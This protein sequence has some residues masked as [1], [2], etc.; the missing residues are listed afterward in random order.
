MA[1]SDRPDGLSVVVI[2]A[3]IVG[4][5][6]A[7]WLARDG[8]RVT[9][10]DRA[11]YGEVASFGNGGVLAA[12]SIVPVTTPSLL[13]K[14]PLMML[15]PG[16][17]VFLRWK[18]VPRLTPWLVRYLSHCRASE[19]RRIAAAL[20]PIIGDSLAQHQALTRGTP[21]ARWVVP[22][23]YVYVY[24]DHAAFAADSL[25]WDVR[26]AAGVAWQVLDGEALRAFDPLI[27][28]D[29]RVAVRMPEH[30]H[31][32][33]PGRYLR[34]LG[35]HLES[36]GGSVRTAEARDFRIEGDRLT[37]VETDQ[38]PLPCDRAVLAGGV[39]SK[40]LAARLGLRVPL[41]T[42]RGYHLELLDPSHMPAHPCM[43]AA[44]KFVVTPMEGRL[45]LAGI[46][47]LGGLDDPPGEAPFRLLERRLREAMPDLRWRET[48]RWMG[49]RPA[50]SDS[51]PA[52]GAPTGR[53]DVLMAFGHHHVGLTGG[54]KTGR[55]VAD[56]IAGR[57]PNI[58]M[59]PYSPDRFAR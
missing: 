26:R 47:E 53:P 55:L 22:S 9:V 1:S 58:D 18:Q 49:H 19:V 52:I 31:I 56:M 39:W 16:S 27:A 57:R 15:D 2:G 38:G 25:T 23:D 20:H 37:A 7:I 33:D 41:E 3:G 48:R 10:I 5:S 51:I 40:P 43:V 32:R 13:I 34:D 45:R 30:G 24:P 11:P 4:L 6:S 36:L 46:V 50:P 8:H 44:G 29:R 14:G 21:A 28:G 59:R 12:A 42:E 35:A 17:P 54:P